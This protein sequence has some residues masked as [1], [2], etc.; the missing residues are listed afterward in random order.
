MDLMI[1]DTDNLQS[2][3]TSLRT[4]LPQVEKNPS[5]PTQVHDLREKRSAAL[6]IGL[7]VISGTLMGWFTHRCDQ[8]REV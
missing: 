7:T 5:G 6:L 8:I 3:L 2:S 4:S 1:N